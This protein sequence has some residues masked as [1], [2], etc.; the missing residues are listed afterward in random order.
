MGD[1]P[2]FEREDAKLL[3]LKELPDVLLLDELLRVTLELLLVEGLEELTLELLLVEGLEELILALLV[4]GLEELTL[5]LLD[6][7]IEDLDELETLEELDDLEELEDL[8]GA[9]LLETDRL[10]PLDLLLLERDDL[11]ITEPVINIKDKAIDNRTV[12]RFFDCFRVNMAR[13]LIFSSFF[14]IYIQIYFY[15]LAS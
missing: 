5:E 14:P 13:L 15:L 11:A 4:E 2:A 7:E 9:E 1:F 6:L 12:L 8:E 3:A 10:P